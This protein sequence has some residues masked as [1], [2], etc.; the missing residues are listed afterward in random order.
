[1][2][3]YKI[4]VKLKTMDMFRFLMRH[5]Y[6]SFS[7][8]FGL[9]ISILALLSLVLGVADGDRNTTIILGFLALVFTVFNPIRLFMRAQ[10]QIVMNPTFKAPIEYTFGEDGMHIAQG[11]E[12]MDVAWADMRKLVRGKK[13]MVLYLS[14]VVGYIFPKS[15]CGGHYEEIAAMI[16]LKMAQARTGQTPEDQS[17]ATESDSEE[18]AKIEAQKKANA[19]TVRQYKESLQKISLMK[20][21]RG[22]DGPRRYDMPPGEAE[23]WGD[24]EEEEEQE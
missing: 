1:M 9:A 22:G 17:V 8:L 14:K 21:L 4:S 16:E 15:Q 2:R 18:E 13:I 10:K 3:E 12:Q 7:G 5:E 24:D 11:E 19:E 23:I 6:G 20:E